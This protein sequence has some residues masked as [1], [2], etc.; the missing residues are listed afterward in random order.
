MKKEIT[1]KYKLLKSDKDHVLQN[2]EKIYDI[3]IN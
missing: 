3:F 2:P 1:T